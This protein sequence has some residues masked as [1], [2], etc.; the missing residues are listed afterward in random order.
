MYTKHLSQGELIAYLKYYNI[1]V[2][3]SKNADIIKSFISMY[4]KELKIRQ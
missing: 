4:D 3:D 2:H 1:L